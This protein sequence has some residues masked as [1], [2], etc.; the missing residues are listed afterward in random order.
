MFACSLLFAIATS[1]NVKYATLEEA[2]EACNKGFTYVLASSSQSFEFPALVNHFT[3]AAHASKIDGFFYIIDLAQTPIQ[4]SDLNATH[5][6]CVVFGSEGMFKN[7]QYNGIEEEYINAFMSTNAVSKPKVI[8][9]KEELNQ[10]YSTSSIALIVAFEGASPETYPTFSDFYINHYHELTV[11]YADPSLF[12]KPGF[13]LY[14]YVD[15]VLVELPDLTEMSDRDIPQVLNRNLFPEFLKLNGAVIGQYEREKQIYVVLMLV[16]ED[17]YLSKEQLEL[18]RKIKEETGLN[19]T[20]CDVENSQILSFRYGLPDSLDST[21]A[22]IDHSKDRE[23]KYMLKDQL[24]LDNALK[25]IDDVKEGRAT[26]F[27]KSEFELI[28]S[29]DNLTS[30]TANSLLEMIEAKDTFVIV[31]YQ[32]A[33]ETLD[34]YI[35]ATQIL[36]P[37]HKDV[38][39]GK[40]S[41]RYN[42]WP[43]DLPKSSEVPYYMVFVKGKNVYEGTIENTA[44][45]IVQKLTEALNVNQEL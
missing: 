23:L 4:P 30:V 33:Y 18:A 26:P 19:V 7:V 25:L 1:I 16:M 43:I 14:R 36:K 32:V 29:N 12:E 24:N 8:K 27:W 37:E 39:F 15:S 2:K 42:D 38:T 11:V 17:F 13:Y 9:T 5:F 28:K 22:V 40:F 20:Y 35:N 44:E 45:A 6:P 21:L 3:N 34:A 10:L 41:L 31:L